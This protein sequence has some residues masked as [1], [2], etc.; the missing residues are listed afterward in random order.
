[1]VE[2]C[3]RYCDQSIFVDGFYA[4]STDARVRD[5]VSAFREKTGAEPVLSDAQA[6]DAAG[7]LVQVMSNGQVTDRDGLRRALE[8]VPGYPG[9]TGTLKFDANGETVRDPFVL[10]IDDQTIQVWRPTKPQG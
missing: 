10:T 1:M 2:K 3:E 4:A 7:V 8:S 9:V 5:F 6:Y